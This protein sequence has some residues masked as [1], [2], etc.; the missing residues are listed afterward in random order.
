[1]DLE[2]FGFSD[3]RAEIAKVKEII[4][5]DKGSPSESLLDSDPYKFFKNKI[6]FVNRVRE[7]QNQQCKIIKDYV[8]NNK[9][10]TPSQKEDLFTR[11][12]SVK[13]GAA[14]LA[15]ADNAILKKQLEN[16]EI[17]TELNKK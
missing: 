11:I 6:K 3:A 7:G 14:N 12:Y 15:D 16:S 4:L 2:Y 9:L 17:L 1:M 13:K 8:K 5:K 10:L